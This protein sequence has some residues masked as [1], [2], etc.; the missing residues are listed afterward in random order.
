MQYRAFG[1]LDWRVSALGFGCMR[2]PYQEGDYRRI[3]EPEATQ[4]I[5]YA[6]DHGVNY[7]DTAYNYHDGNSERFLGRAL[8][9]GYRE[10]VKLATKMF[11]LSIKEYD[12]FDRLLSEQ[13]ERLQTG[14]VDFYLLHGMNHRWWPRLR[15]L[16]VLDWAE[17]AADDGRIRH[18]GFSFHDEFPTFKEIV[19]AYS[20]WTLCQ[21]QYNYMD[22]EHQ[23]GT[24]GLRY[25]AS[26]GLAVVIM[27][28]LLGGWLAHAP[29]ETEKLLDT[30]LKTRTPA[31]W[32]LQWLWNHPEVSVVLSGMSTMNQVEENV[33]SA[34][35]SN[36]NHL[37]ERELALVDQLRTAFQKLSPIPCTGCGY[38]KP[39]PNNVDIPYN[40]KLF[41]DGVM[42]ERESFW[43]ARRWYRFMKEGL[44]GDYHCERGQAGT[45][46]QCQECEA[47][48]PQS[49][50]IS[51]LMPVVHQVL[52]EDMPYS[53]VNLENL[54][55]QK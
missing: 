55:L 28:P 52:G 33:V 15:D 45:C 17:G 19:D 41:N 23:A 46:V 8:R 1:R 39:C 3:R 10:K 50:P 32:G 51:R 47:K 25:A 14:Y 36:T 9:G 43:R 34:D 30:A 13:L 21:I 49:I 48:C 31:E 29:Q 20:K 6:I 53:S 22:T 16:G 18:L 5:H 44:K 7:V 2:L 27:E 54:M 12:D 38:C 37:S 35:R 24:K 40:F 42:Y 4:M 26:K 11:P